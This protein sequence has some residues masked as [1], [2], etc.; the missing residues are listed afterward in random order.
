[1][2]CSRSCIA[3]IRSLHALAELRALL[4]RQHLADVEHRLLDAPAR[5]VVLGEHLLAQRFGG[6]GVD[7]RRGVDLQ[8][9]RAQNARGVVL[10]LQ[11]GGGGCAIGLIWLRCA[12]VAFRPSSM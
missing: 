9:L 12:S 5:L 2:R 7:G 3:A 8:G 10:R 1:M 11:I 4:R 6:V